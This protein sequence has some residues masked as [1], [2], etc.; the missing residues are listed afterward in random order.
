MNLKPFREF[1]ENAVRKVNIGCRNKPLP[2][3]INIDINTNNTFADAYCDGLILDIFEDESLEEIHAV[4][5]AEHLDNESFLKAIRNWHRK[6]VIGGKLIL[7]VP[8][9]E[10]ASALLLLTK[11]KNIVK[12][13]FYGSQNA[14][15]PWDYHKSLHT[16]DSISK[17]L[18]EAG[19]SSVKEWN[20]WDKFP[21]N[22]C[23][24]YASAVYPH[25]LKKIKMDNGRI[26]DLGGI[27]LSINV[28]ATK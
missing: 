15:D 1:K 10:K 24:T 6:L 13:L 19:F 25:M 17:E 20:Y 23:D 21:Y 8:D 9:M 27:Q 12:S 4:H 2:T 5:M 16:K 14:G 22:Y 11:D 7:S 18:L 3:F 26:V 28:E